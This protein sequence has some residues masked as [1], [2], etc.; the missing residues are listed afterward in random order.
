M[1]SG[2]WVLGQL[3]ANEPPGLLGAVGKDALVDVICTS[4]ARICRGVGLAGGG[5]SGSLDR[6]FL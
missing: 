1:P 6:R 4:S 2:S 5:K 3:F